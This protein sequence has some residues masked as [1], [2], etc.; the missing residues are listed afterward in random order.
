ME[1]AD[2]FSGHSTDF[3]ELEGSVDQEAL[4]RL[5]GLFSDVTWKT[6]DNGYLLFT[7]MKKDYRDFLIEFIHQ[8]GEINSLSRKELNR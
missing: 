2:H 6:Y 4:D 1:N 7:I 3:Y 8:G 5:S